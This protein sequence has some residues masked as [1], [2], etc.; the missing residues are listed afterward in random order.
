MVNGYVTLPDEY[1]EGLGEIGIATLRRFL[2]NGGRVLAWCESTV[3]LSEKLD[4]A[5]RFPSFH[6]PANVFSTLGSHV[7]IHYE[8][9]PLNLG[10]PESSSV[11]HRQKTVFELDHTTD[12][13][14]LAHYAE[15]DILENGFL[16]GEEYLA[17]KPAAL[18][19]CY[20]K[21]DCIFLG[22]DPQY[23][24]QQDVSFKLIFN[25]LL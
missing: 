19:I 1:Y 25:A 16:I 23:R 11:Y 17:G 9:S 2:S 5:I 6:L 10:L 13:E 14:V 4:L 22:F 15:S 3:Y 18:R 12:I 24:M 21:G 20:G 8:H 7:K